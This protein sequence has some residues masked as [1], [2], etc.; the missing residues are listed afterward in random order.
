MLEIDI[1]K[2]PSFIMGEKSGKKKISLEV[3]KKMLAMDISPEIIIQVTGLDKSD[4]ENL[5]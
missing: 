3:A 4:L 2:L 5:N 1:E